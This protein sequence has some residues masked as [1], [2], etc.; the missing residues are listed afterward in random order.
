MLQQKIRMDMENAMRAR[1]SVKVDTLR[2]LITAITNEM[3]R[4]GRM[5]IEGLPDEE[6][7][8]IIRREMKKREEA[9][10]AY[11]Q[12]GRSELANKEAQEYDILV[13]YTPPL[14][15]EEEVRAVVEKKKADLGITEKK[16]A[17]ILM[18]R[19]MKDLSGKADGTLVKSV[20]DSLFS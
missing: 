5:L 18:G 7:V 8:A 9:G 2:M 16:D 12:A 11:L 1:E 17:G 20:V 6:V 19:V 3:K 13:A 10:A 14:M 4:G 15:S